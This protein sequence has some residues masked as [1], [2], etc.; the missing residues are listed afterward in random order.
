MANNKKREKKKKRREEKLRKKKHAMRFGSGG[1]ILDV[2][3]SNGGSDDNDEIWDQPAHFFGFTGFSGSAGLLRAMDHERAQLAARYLREDFA[4]S[5]SEIEDWIAKR[6]GMKLLGDI[7]NNSAIG[8]DYGMESLTTVSSGSPAALV[9]RFA[10]TALR[11]DPEQL[12]A[13]TALILLKPIADRIDPLKDLAAKGEAA[14]GRDYFERNRSASWTELLD[15]RPWLRVIMRLAETHCQLE[16]AGEAVEILQHAIERVPGFVA[17]VGLPLAFGLA[18]R[19]DLSSLHSVLQAREAARVGLELWTIAD[20]D[21]LEVNISGAV[22]DM[23]EA[24]ASFA[25]DDRLNA[26]GAFFRANDKTPNL[27]EALTER[28]YKYLNMD[29]AESL[30]MALDP[31]LEKHPLFAAWLHD[32]ARGY[33]AEEIEA[34]KKSYAP[35]LSALFELGRPTN[36]QEN[37]PDDYAALGLGREQL[38][39]LFRMAGDDALLSSDQ[40]NDF[41]A[42]I[43]AWIAIGHFGDASYA[44][45]LSEIYRRIHLQLG[46][47]SFE[48]VPVVFGRLGISSVKPLNDIVCDKQLSTHYRAAGFDSAAEVAKYHPESRAECTAFLADA[49]RNYDP[50]EI[51]F[52]GCLICSLIKMGMEET[53]PDIK[54]AFDSDSVELI[55]CGE[56]E[57]VETDLRKAASRLRKE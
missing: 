1:G 54:R 18:V 5:E 57:S 9:T 21:S 19:G 4:M 35:P 3:S 55:I 43:H 50:A 26:S 28:D 22:A 52:N 56:Y 39:E 46:D 41:Y 53:L 33:T 34:A 15:A 14:L 27:H 11:A 29:E 49:M 38:S 31:I 51:E 6:D 37:A 30:L 48:L 10:D 45:R 8:R 24:L 20:L 13:L 44:E 16:R 7:C 23:L 17:A 25:A 32:G 2:P 40:E 36:A 42:L 47:W 12:D